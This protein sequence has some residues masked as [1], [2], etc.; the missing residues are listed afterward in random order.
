MGPRHRTPVAVGVLLVLT[1]LGLPWSHDTTVHVPGFFAPSTC[2]PTWDGTMWCSPGF[3]S[4][5]LTTGSP[6]AAGA[7]SPV[8]VLLVGALVLVALALRTAS[9][10]LVLAAGAV[11]VVAGVLGATAVLAGPLAA[12]AGGVLLVRAGRRP[13]ATAR[14]GPVPG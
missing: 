1:S 13:A 11:A 8:R 7:D 9:R 12:A 5:S 14:L 2:I 6:A 3:V 4:P 10:R